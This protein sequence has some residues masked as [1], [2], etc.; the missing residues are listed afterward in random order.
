MSKLRIPL[1]LQMFAEGEGKQKNQEPDNSSQS[2]NQEG[3]QAPFDYDKL[4]SI[5][6]GKQAVAEDTILKN[7]FKQQGLTQEEVSNAIA[8]YKQK[9]SEST[10]NYEEIQED[11]KRAEQQA[12]LYQI[13][14]VATLEA[15]GLG[16]DKKTIPYVIKMADL[17]DAMVDGKANEENIK[18]AINKVLEDVPQLKPVTQVQQQGGFRIGSERKENQNGSDQD[19]L[20]KIFGNK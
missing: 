8:T 14:N 7:Y 4:A 1:D 20:A 2:N 16:I 12:E 15:L 19:V 11:L 10:P 18:K 3:Q 6:S 13:Q 9:K 17:S 5:I